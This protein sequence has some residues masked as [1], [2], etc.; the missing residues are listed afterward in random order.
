M[1]TPMDQALSVAYKLEKFVENQYKYRVKRYEMLRQIENL[2]IPKV[3][4]E[5]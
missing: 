5:I 3:N 4:F 2:F 1:V